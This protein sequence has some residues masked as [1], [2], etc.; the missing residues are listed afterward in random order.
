[1]LK[2]L[3][4]IKKFISKGCPYELQKQA[5]SDLSKT[6]K[7]LLWKD[8]PQ[9]LVLYI[10]TKLI[11]RPLFPFTKQVNQNLFNKNHSSKIK[12]LLKKDHISAFYFRY[13]N[14]QKNDNWN[15]RHNYLYHKTLKHCLS[16][17][18][19]KPNAE[20]LNDKLKFHD[21]CLENNIPTPHV[22]SDGNKLQTNSLRPWDVNKDF[23]IKRTTGSQ[24]KGF[25]IF[26]YNK[27]ED[28]YSNT[29]HEQ[30]IEK[31]QMEKHLLAII[32]NSNEGYLVQEKISSHEYFKTLGNGALSVIRILSILDQNNNVKLFRPILKIPQREM[33]TT[34]IH[35]GAK[36][37]TVNCESGKIDQRIA[38]KNTKPDKLDEFTEP[39]PYW[40]ELKDSITKSHQK[41]NDIPLVGWD[42]TITS[43]GPCIIEG[44]T[45]P[46]LDIHQ[47]QPYGPFIGTPFYDLFLNQLKHR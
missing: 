37:Y 26:S 35:R 14:F 18:A 24:G 6:W 41:L 38:E 9:F 45:I 34:E 32:N 42:V 16:L 39:L 22:F 31:K 30:F 15:N 23:I 2:Y 21:F 40:N 13:F 27:A 25:Q 12:Q 3:I 5:P 29:N 4:Q 44:N 17:L 33:V 46:S 20:I 43:E 11:W 19:E 1:M 10:I 28:K 36:A 47:L 7:S 8:K